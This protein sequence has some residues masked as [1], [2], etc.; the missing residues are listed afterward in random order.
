M[1]EPHISALAKRLAEQNNVDW[2]KLTGT[3][4]G[5]K[6]VERD[7]LDYL[8]RVMAG[9]EAVDPTPEP[10]PEGMEAW[11]DQD[12][13]SYFDRNAARSAQPAPAA[14]PAPLDAAPGFDAP[15]FDAPAP[16]AP[17]LD[18][19]S[20]DAPAFDAPAYEAPAAE[21]PAPEAAPVWGA[22]EAPLA[23]AL[24]DTD[25]T[26]EVLSDDIFLFDDGTDEPEPEAATA[27]PPVLAPEP[28]P[29]PFTA[30]AHAAPDAGGFGDVDD[31]DDALLVADDDLDA[32]PEA[33][34]ES[35]PPL[36]PLETAG[37]L[38]ERP[39]GG[40]FDLD[41]GGDAYGG[42]AD[43]QAGGTAWGGEEL[44][45]GGDA[46]SDDLEAGE[47]PD[48]FAGDADAAADAAAPAAEAEATD[49]ALTDAPADTAGGAWF[50]TVDGYGAQGTPF[51]AGGVGYGAEEEPSEPPAEEP[52]EPADDV[53]DLETASSL[54]E[55]EAL[56]DV[57]ALEPDAPTLDAPATELPDLGAPSTDAPDA[58][59]AEAD[60]PYVADSPAAAGASDGATGGA[61]AGPVPL[62]SL[63]ADTPAPPARAGELPLARS[64]TVFRRHVDLSALAA[65][66]LAAGLELGRDEPVAPA[67]FLLRAVAKAAAEQ[68]WTTGQVALAEL[69]GG[70]L[71]RRVDGATQRPFAE[72]VTELSHPGTEE[73]E[74]GLV[75][76]DLTGFDLDE[77]LL[78]L[79][80][81]AVTLGRVLYDTQRGTHRSTLTLTGDVPLERGAALMARVAELLESPVRLLL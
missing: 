54:E 24:D 15:A 22:P 23:D 27:L 3:G 51:G 17:S 9:E 60:E 63:D 45:L 14:D 28:A 76:V 81:P 1:S 34:T 37:D 36:E 62:R 50:E 29:E 59:V 13:P 4:E 75:A 20:A 53:L 5:G 35:V 7:V 12:A 71:L 64:G 31:V 61:A 74:L 19:P 49:A 47:L 18:V 58:F 70:L 67:P 46:P 68:G 48:L 42:Q 25:D 78:D 44:R 66:Q 80:V 69:E 2:R 52:S 10:L 41:D 26:D 21:A 32:A 39:L 8:A 11:P 56:E 16:D 55:L 79:D 77:A 33:P 38:F 6:V 57:Q 40:S 30:P 72:L 43:G 65:A 73:D